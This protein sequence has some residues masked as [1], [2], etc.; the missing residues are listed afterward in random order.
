MTSIIM[1]HINRMSKYLRERERERDSERERG[2]GGGGER[3]REERGER[4]EQESEQVSERERLWKR[5]GKRKLG[6]QY[7][8]EPLEVAAVT[9]MRF[10]SH[11]KSSFGNCKRCKLN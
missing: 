11:F 4:G 2:R 8:L 5:E 1:F 7:E 10:E 3:E 9:P 6:T